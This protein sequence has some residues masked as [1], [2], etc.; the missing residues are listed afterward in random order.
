MMSDIAPKPTPT[1]LSVEY[2]DFDEL[3]PLEQH[4]INRKDDRKPLIMNET[5]FGLL[6]S[7]KKRR[8]RSNNKQDGEQMNNEEIIA[9]A[10]CSIANS[11]NDIKTMEALLQ[12]KRVTLPAALFEIAEDIMDE[13]KRRTLDYDELAV[14]D[15]KEPRTKFSDFAAEALKDPEVRKGYDE[16]AQTDW[17]DAFDIADRKKQG[18]YGEEIDN[19]ELDSLLPESEN[20]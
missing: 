10:L 17:E 18:P 13:R 1:I 3:N 4:E 14:L 8:H 2:K 5:R 20:K 16:A 15:T 9:R 11:F 6:R 12:E 7:L 19:D